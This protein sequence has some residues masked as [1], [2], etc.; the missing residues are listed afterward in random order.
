MAFI[1]RGGAHFIS[2]IPNDQKPAHAFRFR[3][4]EN[5]SFK[6]IFYEYD[7]CFCEAS[8][9]LKKVLSEAKRQTIVRL[10]FQSS[11]NVIYFLFFFKSSISSN[12]LLIIYSFLFSI[13]CLISGEHLVFC[14]VV[15]LES[16]PGKLVV[17]RTFQN[18][19]VCI[20]RICAFILIYFEL[21]SNTVRAQNGAFRIRLFLLSLWN[22]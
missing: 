9:D 16:P 10:S 1:S 12:T 14:F 19:I 2:R 6:I 17:H 7:R 21:P 22:V 13:S 20:T 5:V 8:V 3:A 4:N 18:F 11:N 15:Y